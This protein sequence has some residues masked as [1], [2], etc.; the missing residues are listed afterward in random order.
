MPHFRHQP[1]RFGN[2]E[3]QYYI[4][5][6]IF[7]PQSTV[8]HPVDGDEDKLRVPISAEDAS[9]II[10]SPAPDNWIADDR[11]R[12]EAFAQTLKGGSCA[13]V[14]AMVKL[15]FHHKHKNPDS[16]TKL[17]ACDERSLNDGK[18][19]ISE[20]LAFALKIT[21]DEAVQAVLEH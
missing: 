11:E 21:K 2:T 1:M 15:I 16:V 3:K 13:E 6:P 4:L 10:S 18:K 14:A 12:R 19:L 5:K 9:R 7:E 17:R 20:E 8:Y